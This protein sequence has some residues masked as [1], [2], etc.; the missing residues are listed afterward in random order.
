MLS[1]LIGIAI[2]RGHIDDRSVPVAR[3]VPELFA[4]FPDAARQ[5]IRVE[6]LLTMSAGLNWN[7]VDLSG[8]F[9]S[10]DW[11]DFVIEQPVVQPPGQTFLYSTGLTHLAAHVLERATGTPPHEFARQHLFDRLG[12]VPA[13]WERDPQGRDVGGFELYL[14]PRD[15]A[16]FGEH[17]LG[18][19]NE[20][21]DATV[22]PEWR[23]WSTSHLIQA[24]PALGYGGWWWRRS[25]GGHDDVFFAW[26]YGGQ[27]IFLFPSLDLNVVVTSRWNVSGNEAL[28]RAYAVFAWLEDQLLPAV[29]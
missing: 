23:D 14:R 2:A 8:W 3:I 29:K 5:A 16:R 9:Y 1:A 12:I 6:D 11:I 26:G 13:R 18:H 22:P 27:F 21:I 17:Y 10:P 7:E 24:E 28:V 25:F 4:R 20:K 15:M 19:D